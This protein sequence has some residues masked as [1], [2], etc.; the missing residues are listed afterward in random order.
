MY[1]TV[2]EDR[3]LTLEKQM[4]GTYRPYIFL[5]ASETQMNYTVHC[6]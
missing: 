4:L 6:P 5:N 2:Q 3:H 1:S